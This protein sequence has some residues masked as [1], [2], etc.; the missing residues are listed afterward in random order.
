MSFLEDFPADVMRAFRFMGG[1]LRELCLN[2]SF[3]ARMGFLAVQG[4]GLLYPDSIPS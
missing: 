3:P 2:L 1:A 4:K